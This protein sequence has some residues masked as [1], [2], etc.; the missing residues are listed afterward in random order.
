[1]VDIANRPL[2]NFF[3][4]RKW[5]LYISAI[6]VIAC[7]F[8]AV[9]FSV[10]LSNL[11]AA[12]KA[13]ALTTS[14]L[15]KENEVTLETLQNDYNRLIDNLV[16]RLNKLESDQAALSEA[17]RVQLNSRL[18]ETQKRMRAE[19]TG[20]LQLLSASIASQDTRVKDL[21]GNVSYRIDSVS[22]VIKTVDSRIAGLESSLSMV[23]GASTGWSRAPASIDAKLAS[24]F[25]KLVG[26]I[27]DDWA[28]LSALVYAPIPL[29]LHVDEAKKRS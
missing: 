15:I 14:F 16:T 5:L 23:Y 12:L 26:L 11:S 21:Y 18:A 1:M 25:G 10:Q 27:G 17:L 4:P 6:F 29:W 7:V 20:G 9:F 22:E 3:K 28:D 24:E 19:F 8:C 2:L 13:E